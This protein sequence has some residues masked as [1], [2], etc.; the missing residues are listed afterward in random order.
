MRSNPHALAFATSTNCNPNNFHIYR[1]TIVSILRLN[2]L[3]QRFHA[4]AE[5]RYGLSIQAV[6]YSVIETHLA[7]ICAI[8]P[9]LGYTLLVDYIKTNQKKRPTPRI[10]RGETIGNFQRRGFH[11][12][13][14]EMEGEVNNNIRDQDAVNDNM[15][16]EDGDRN[17]THYQDGLFNDQPPAY[18]TGH[19]QPYRAR[20][21]E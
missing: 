19:H 7:I 5:R 21:I 13:N 14:Y 20:T 8:L 4:P 12:E 11:G 6:M 9:R 18:M 2:L 17:N 3:N 10:R 15:L 1:T 16:H